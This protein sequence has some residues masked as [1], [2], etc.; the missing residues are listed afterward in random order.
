MT[1]KGLL[2]RLL[3]VELAIAEKIMDSQDKAESSGLF[4]S[5]MSNDDGEGICT[6]EDAAPDLDSARTHIQAAIADV[7][8][9]IKGAGA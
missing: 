9:H 4:T 8:R 5:G 2:N 3:Y 6:P 1:N 7:E